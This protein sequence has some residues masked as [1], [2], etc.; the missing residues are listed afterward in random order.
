MKFGNK[1]IAAVLAGCIILSGSGMRAIAEDTSG[2]KTD[3]GGE[4]AS[5]TEDNGGYKVDAD[6]IASTQ[7]PQTEEDLE[8]QMAA[9]LKI[10][11]E[12]NK[13]EDW[14]QGPDV[15]AD[16]AIVMDVN[17]GAILYGKQ[18]DKKEYP[19]SITKIMTALLALENG[20]LDADKVKFSQESVDFLES[21]DAHIGMR[22]GEEIPLREA[23]Y[24]MLLASANEVS[25]AIAENI[26]A[27][28]GIGYD[29]FIDLMTTRAKELG[30]K[31]SHFVNANGLHDENHYVSA[32][33][34]AI[35]SSAAYQYDAFR[36]VIK[37]PEHTIPET[38][39]VNE[40]RT[41]QQNHKMILQGNQYYYEGATGGKTGYTDQART[42]LVSFAERQGLQLVCVVLRTRGGLA[43][44]DTAALL[45]YGF[46]NFQKLSLKLQETSG[47]IAE[48]P[49]DAYIV[50]PK[51]ASFADAK[52]TITQKKDG[53]KAATLE[54]TYKDTTVGKTD[55]TLSD[56]YLKKQSDEAEKKAE[57]TV[58]KDKKQNGTALW[59]KVLLGLLAFIIA[60][61]TILYAYLL[62]EKERRRQER[63]RRKRLAKRKMER[64]RQEQKEREEE[65]RYA[66][67]GRNRGRY[68]GSYI[69]PYNKYQSGPANRNPYGDAGRRQNRTNYNQNDRMN[70]NRNPKNRKW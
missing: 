47:D 64:R 52:R 10:K 44:T 68:G 45:D 69:I 54:Y 50:L 57:E 36:E 60:A 34:M 63:I 62:R 15:T 22:P 49:E 18:I 55:V 16:A 61:G 30:C 6:T 66:N 23:M 9:Q 37:T 1:F 40:T 27:K 28:L 70:Q 14:P 59:M 8:K 43:Y 58:A 48:I 20:D 39:L 11:P 38:N 65:E 42:T 21:G 41:F 35:I 24:G 19:A 5:Q 29:G 12:T 26:G 2:Q 56:A 25:H 4:T 3:A 13:I 51:G 31:N 46:E 33:D 17:S 32:R 53:E 7:V 67:M